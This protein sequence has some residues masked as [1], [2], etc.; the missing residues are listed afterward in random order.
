MVGGNK[1]RVSIPE[2]PIKTSTLTKVAA[3]LNKFQFP[4]DQLRLGLVKS[5][6]VLSRV[7]IPEGPIKTQSAASNHYKTNPFQFP[8]DQLRL[9]RM[10]I[11]RLPNQCFNSR[12]TN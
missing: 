11:T 3:A 9:S 2:G 7:S 10:T 6:P 4:K 12:R 5:G 8:K 1:K